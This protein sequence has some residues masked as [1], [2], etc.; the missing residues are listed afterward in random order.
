MHLVEGEV[1]MPAAFD[2][3][4]EFRAFAL[5]YR[6]L[7]GRIA[8]LVGH[9]APTSLICVMRTTPSMCTLAWSLVLV[10]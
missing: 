8:R 6:S 1:D 10:R 2:D 7:L 3:F 9:R 5:E 4:A